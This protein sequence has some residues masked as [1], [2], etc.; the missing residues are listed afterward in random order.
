MFRFP[1]PVGS[2]WMPPTANQNEVLFGAPREE[3][4][5]ERLKAQFAKRKRVRFADEQSRTRSRAKDLFKP[6]MKVMW[7]ERRLSFAIRG[8]T[9]YFFA[10]I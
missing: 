8:R 7:F 4:D 10:C 5:L 6:G 1:G 3:I 2:E 9:L